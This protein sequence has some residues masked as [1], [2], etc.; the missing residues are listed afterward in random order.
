MTSTA[1]RGAKRAGSRLQVAGYRFGAV[2]GH[3]GESAQ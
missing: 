3:Y 1:Y 2:F